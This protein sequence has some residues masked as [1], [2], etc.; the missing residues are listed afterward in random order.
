MLQWH[1]PTPW[2]Q[3]LG[4]LQQCPLW[5]LWS[6]PSSTPE[7]LNAAAWFITGKRKFYHV[8]RSCATTSISC[9][10]VKRILFK[11]CSLFSK[12]PCRAAPSYLTDTRIPVSA[13]NDYCRLHSSSH[14]D[15]IIHALNCPVTDRATFPLVI[16][17][18]GTLY[19]QAF[20][21]YLL[22]HPVSAAISKLN[23]FA[24]RMALIRCSTFVI[25]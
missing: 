6:K 14:S 20:K 21:T 16:L 17:L 24:G 22:H 7:L 12:C 18:P 11:L 25:A 5:H 15:P 23:L 4:L 2:F 9:Q 3:P 19:Q 13:T 1:W 10:W 8:A